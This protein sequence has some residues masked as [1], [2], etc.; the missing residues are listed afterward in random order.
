MEMNYSRNS[1]A[2]YIEAIL[3][4]GPDRV[5]IGIV[6]DLVELDSSVLA[7][8]RGGEGPTDFCL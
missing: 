1:P 5:E 4:H 7:R 8:K 3:I 2:F 6:L